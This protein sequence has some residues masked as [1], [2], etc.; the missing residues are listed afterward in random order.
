MD[1]K[2]ALVESAK[3]TAL[4]M[5]K[6]VPVLGELLE[7]LEKYKDTLEEQQREL[8]LDLLCE[9]VGELEKLQSD[10]F[11][12]DEISKIVRKIVSSAL[13]SEYIDKTEFFRNALLNCDQK[14]DN[15]EKLKFVEI[16]RH[17]SRPAL[18]VLAKEKELHS[19][20]GPDYS[21]EVLQ[22]ELIKNMPRFDPHLIESCINELYSL[23]VFSSTLDF[24]PDGGRKNH[25]N[26]G[27]A[28]YTKLTD[29]FINFVLQ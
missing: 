12:S 3:T 25:F 1:Q 4:A 2:E 10:Y 9:R 22:N 21:Q 17:A 19:A 16:L 23:G 29:R 24:H 8:F 5:I 18:L 13:N 27:T 6:R 20:R 28:A 26:K 14:I 15:A 11:K 7:G